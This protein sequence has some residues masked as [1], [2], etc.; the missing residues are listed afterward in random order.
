MPACTEFFP[1]TALDH[2]EDVHSSVPASVDTREGSAQPQS[3][4][5]KTYANLMDSGLRVSRRWA[6]R[7]GQDVATKTLG[8]VSAPP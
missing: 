4:K 5:W 3:P 6:T 8:W 1:Y 7:V 2:A